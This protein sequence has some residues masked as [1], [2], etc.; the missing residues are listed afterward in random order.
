MAHAKVQTKSFSGEFMFNYY[1][2][3]EGESETRQLDQ[4]KDKALTLFFVDFSNNPL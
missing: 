3:I 2:L 4:K 1:N